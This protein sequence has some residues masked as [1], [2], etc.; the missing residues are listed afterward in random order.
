VSLLFEA[1]SPACWPYSCECS[2]IDE[3]ILGGVRD[4]PTGL[5]VMVRPKQP[6][7]RELNKPSR[8]MQ[9]AF[10]RDCIG[11][12]GL[13]DDT[14]QGPWRQWECQSIDSTVYPDCLGID[15]ILNPECPGKSIHSVRGRY[16][17]PLTLGLYI[18]GGRAEPS[19]HHRESRST[20]SILSRKTAPINSKISRPF[21]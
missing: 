2:E 16:C 7:A 6:G 13:R 15:S 20:S 21:P 11:R 9:A 19:A 10:S 3:S 17:R 4:N 5:P 8:A 14:P 18:L 1:Q 12:Q